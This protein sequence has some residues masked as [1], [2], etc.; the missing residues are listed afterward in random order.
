MKKNELIFI[1][2]I[3]ESIKNIEDFVEEIS[4]EQFLKDKEKQHAVVR[5]IEVIG[6]AT[7][8]IPDEIRNRYPSIPWRDM[9]GMRDKIIHGYFMV[10]FETVWLV[11]KV[12]VPKLKKQMREIMEAEKKENKRE[13]RGILEIHMR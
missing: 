1:G 4:K 11:V 6:E 13:R 5:A 12:E 3:Q 9:A 7:K 8:N 10:D 2:H